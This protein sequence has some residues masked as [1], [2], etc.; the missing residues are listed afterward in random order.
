MKLVDR[1][2]KCLRVELANMRT[3][4]SI[5]KSVLEK[6]KNKLEGWK[7]SLLSQV[8]RTVMVKSILQ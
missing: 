4:S 8:G 5:F 7:S 2:L 1:L 3:K 6:V